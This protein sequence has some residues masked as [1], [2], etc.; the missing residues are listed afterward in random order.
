MQIAV[1]DANVL[2]PNALCDVLLRLAEEDLFLPRWSADILDEVR[3]NLPGLSPTA[4]ERRIRFMN[5]AFEEACVTGYAHFI[6][7]MAN[8]PKDRHVLAAAVAADADKIITCNLKDFRT[9]H[10]EPHGVEAEHPDVF[11]LDALARE[12]ALIEMVVRAQAADTGRHGPKLTSLEV[13][14]YL[15]A[16][17]APRFAVALRPLFGPS[18][19]GA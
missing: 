3:R 15:A 6:S 13:L 11:L 19:E 7:E 16:A 12:P 18:L 10:C 5:A 1:L 8:H 4:V 14:D 2:I 9:E 17:G